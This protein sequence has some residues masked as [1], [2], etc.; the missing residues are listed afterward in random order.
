MIISGSVFD[1]MGTPL[2]GVNIF[3]LKNGASYGVGGI[4]DYDG[5]F[6][7]EIDDLQADQIV[8]LSYLGFAPVEIT[9]GTLQNKRITM[10]E[11][12]EALDEVVITATRK[13]PKSIKQLNRTIEIISLAGGLSLMGLIIYSMNKNG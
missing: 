2:M 6:E 4:T 3:P 7:I 12:A 13:K 5:N 11:E 9:A 1:E 10:M 8:K